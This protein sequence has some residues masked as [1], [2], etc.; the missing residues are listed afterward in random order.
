MTNLKNVTRESYEIYLA[1]IHFIAEENHN[2][3]RL[4][5]NCFFVP[6]SRSRTLPWSKSHLAPNTKSTEKTVMTIKFTLLT[7]SKFEHMSLS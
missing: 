5:G 2:Q 1:L 6:K 3:T 7:P 4:K